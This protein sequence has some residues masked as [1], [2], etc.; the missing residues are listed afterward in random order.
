MQDHNDNNREEE[1]KRNHKIK[2][3]YGSGDYYKHFIKETGATH[4]SRAMFGSI[5]REFNTHVRDRISTKGAEYILPQR[6]GKIELRKVKTEV[7]IAEDGSIINNLPVNW[8]ATRELWAESPRSKEKGTKIRYTNEHTDGH[9]F[10]IYYRKSKANFKNKSIYK[11]Q[12]N[13]TMKRQLSASIFA[14]KIDAFLN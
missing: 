14:G 5:I 9:T 6:T 2:T 12:F 1:D 13:R 4:I 3:D 11:M 10:R 8:K 7:K